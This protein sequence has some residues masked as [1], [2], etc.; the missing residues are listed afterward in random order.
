[1]NSGYYLDFLGN[2]WIVDPASKGTQLGFLIITPDLI[3]MTQLSWIEQRN[4]QS[5]LQPVYSFVLCSRNHTAFRALKM[6]TG[7]QAYPTIDLLREAINRE[8]TQG[9]ANNRY[10]AVEKLL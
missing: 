3:V 2:I 5:W 6:A 4:I 1:M 8:A 7:K 10:V 9:N